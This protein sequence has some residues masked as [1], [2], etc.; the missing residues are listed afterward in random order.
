MEKNSDVNI[1][2]KK[3]LK[4]INGIIHNCFK[5]VRIKENQDDSEIYKLFER[6][7]VLRTKKDIESKQE[8]I[9]VEAEL[10]EKCA[11]ENYRKI[12]D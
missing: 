6:R 2:T 4:R 9:H 10:A 12:K 3:F 5:K 8:L 11:E 7:K 1:L